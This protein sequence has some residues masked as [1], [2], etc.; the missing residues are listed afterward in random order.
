MRP[1]NWRSSAPNCAAGFGAVGGR[2]KL[3]S[4]HSMRSAVAKTCPRQPRAEIRGSISGCRSAS[5]VSLPPAGYKPSSKPTDLK[6]KLSLPDWK[7]FPFREKTTKRW[8]E[9]M[10]CDTSSPRRSG[11]HSTERNVTTAEMPLSASKRPPASLSPPRTGSTSSRW[12]RFLA[13]RWWWPK[14]PEQRLVTPRLP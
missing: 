8:A 7:R 3:A 1:S 6:W 2:C 13:N 10:A 4:V 12:L 5:A 11:H 14:P 9:L